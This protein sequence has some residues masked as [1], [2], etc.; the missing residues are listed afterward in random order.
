VQQQHRLGEAVAGRA[1]A[2]ELSSCPSL[3][4]AFRCAVSASRLGV[5]SP[6]SCAA[7]LAAGDAASPGVLVGKTA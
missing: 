1:S 4:R 5:L 7:C 2:A 6:G 3:L